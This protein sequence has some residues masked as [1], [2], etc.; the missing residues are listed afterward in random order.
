LAAGWDA[1]KGRG[2][3]PRWKCP[4]HTLK[5]YA[6][7]K[8]GEVA[9][10][11]LWAEMAT[12]AYGMGVGASL[13]D[14]EPE[15]ETARGL[16]VD[17]IAGEI[18]RCLEI[19]SRVPYLT[20]PG[21]VGWDAARKLEAAGQVEIGE[22]SGHGWREVQIAANRERLR[23]PTRADFE[24]ARAIAERVRGRAEQGEPEHCEPEHCEPEHR[25]PRG[26]LA[27]LWIPLLMVLGLEGLEGE[28]E[29]GCEDR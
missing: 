15:Q 24:R 12:A 5:G 23:A 13:R 21:H 10:G 20:R 27:R 19:P 25:G 1:S 28:P 2:G 17:R 18:L 3:S 16:E 7:R 14:P 26:W 29:P 11:L 4:K 9:K 8:L 6:R 22:P